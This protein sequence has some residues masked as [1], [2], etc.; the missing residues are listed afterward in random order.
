MSQ[1]DSDRAVNSEPYRPAGA[2]DCKYKPY[3]DCEEWLKATFPN[4]DPR[5]RAIAREA[6]ARG[7]QA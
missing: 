1:H 5:Q 4:F 7:R 3:T 2:C 6:W